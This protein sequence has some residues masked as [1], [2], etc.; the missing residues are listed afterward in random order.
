M[1]S[2]F[3][4][5]EMKIFKRQRRDCRLYSIDPFREGLQVKQTQFSGNALTRLASKK[6]KKDS[7]PPTHSLQA[8]LTVLDIKIR[9]ESK[10]KAK[11][12]ARWHLFC[13]WLRPLS[14]TGPP[15]SILVCA[16]KQA[17]ETDHGSRVLFFE[18]EFSERHATRVRLKNRFF[19]S[20]A[21]DDLS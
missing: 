8:I 10:N 15:G 16:K 21:R 13:F 12:Y 9:K 11:V 2:M 5:I 4:R 14:R 3:R 19:V 18:S 1:L 17:L 7:I 6:A 20:L